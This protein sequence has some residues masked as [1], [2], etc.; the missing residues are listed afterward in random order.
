MKILLTL[1]ICAGSVFAQQ[2]GNPTTQQGV[3]PPRGTY[4][5]RNARIVTVS[6]ETMKV[7]DGLPA[8]EILARDV[9]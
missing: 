6:I 7:V 9:R 1:L 5:I 8:L 3:L 4:A 2:I